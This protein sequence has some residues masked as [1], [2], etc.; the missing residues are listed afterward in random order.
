MGSLT[1]AD[2]AVIVFVVIALL[3]TGLYFLNKWSSKKVTE[4]QSLIEKS[5]MLV[6]IYVI[7]K[8]KDKLQNA[9]MPKAVTEQM[10]A[11]YK[12]MKM[13]LVKAKIGPQIITLICD[14]R[15]Y[16]ALTVKKSAQVYI[17]GIYISDMKGLKSK[18]ELKA[19]AKAKLDKE[20]EQSGKSKLAFTL[21]KTMKGIKSKLSKKK[22]EK[23]A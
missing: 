6:T 8:K 13:P 11:V 15:V 4:Q 18:S 7:D 1:L 22:G 17:A 10:P 16:E 19:I 3:A 5:K 20:F 12:F 21:D 14:K 2:I 23:T 9:N